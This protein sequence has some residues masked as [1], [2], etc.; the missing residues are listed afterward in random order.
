MDEARL[1]TVRVWR[2]GQQF[3]AAVRAVGD[4][5]ASLFTEPALMAEFLVQASAAGA[6]ATPPLAPLP[7]APAGA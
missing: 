1:F 4:E 5:R 3:R 7:P 2:H 6:A